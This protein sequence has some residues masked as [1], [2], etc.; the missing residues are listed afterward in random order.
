MVVRK[1]SIE[2]NVLLILET[3]GTTEKD[4]SLLVLR[5]VLGMPRKIG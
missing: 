4:M 5:N 2:K 3:F 1:S